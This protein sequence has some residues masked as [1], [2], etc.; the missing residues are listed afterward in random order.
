MNTEFL[1][2]KQT[3]WRVTGGRRRKTFRPLH[4][5]NPSG[6]KSTFQNK[7]TYFLL[8]WLIRVPLEPHT[9]QCLSRVEWDGMMISYC[10]LEEMKTTKISLWY[11]NLV[12]PE[13]KS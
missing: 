13:Y 9:V 5:A 4:L 6:L 8:I 7:C 10:S 1:K 2:A 3:E 12:L 11:S